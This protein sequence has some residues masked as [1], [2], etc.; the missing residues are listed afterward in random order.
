MAAHRSSASS[1]SP[2]ASSASGG[3]SRGGGSGGGGRKVSV[4]VKRRA[5]GI[6]GGVGDYVRDSAKAVTAQAKKTLSAA[7]ESLRE[8]LDRV[9]GDRKGKAATQIE[10]LGGAIER[11]AHALHA[12]KLDNAADY[13]DAAGGTLK[14]LAQYVEDADLDHLTRDAA[15]LIRRHPR[16]VVGGLLVAGFLAARFLKASQTPPE[17]QQESSRR[18]GGNGANGA[19]RGRRRTG[20]ARAR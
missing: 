12:V 19:T 14:D 15:K 16:A 17:E 5:G 3:S 4:S 7:T 13:I 8:E 1:G 11:A 2:N 18:R 6:T 10:G 9:I 20:R